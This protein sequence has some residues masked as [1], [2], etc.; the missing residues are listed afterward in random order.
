M[1]NCRNLTLSFLLLFIVTPIFLRA[2]TNPLTMELR[3]GTNLSKVDADN[4]KVK[5]GYRAELLAQYYNQSGLYLQSGIGYNHR[6][7][8]AKHIDTS[9]NMQIKPS[10]T[11]DYIH[12]PLM[13]GASLSLSNSI[14]YNMAIG[15]YAA[16]GVGGKYK[17]SVLETGM[18]NNYTG[19]NISCFGDKLLKPFDFGLRAEVGAEYRS[20]TL[21]VGLEQGFV[22]IRKDKNLF[23]DKIRNQNIFLAL[24]YRLF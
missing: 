3:G 22:D 24:G 7:T 17:S 15:V 9:S 12:V 5:V 18:I 8:D 13:G 1:N 14:V 19:Y 2:Q 10:I 4:W 20:F 6:S 16:Y 23:T 11:M 21:T